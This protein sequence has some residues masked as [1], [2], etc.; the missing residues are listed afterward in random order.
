M[1]RFP[2]IAVLVAAVFLAPAA[3][4]ADSD[5]VE[6]SAYWSHRLHEENSIFASI[7]YFPYGIFRMPVGLF[8]SFRNP[9][10][11]TQAVMPPEAH[12]LDPYR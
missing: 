1:R 10:P 6:A 4:V 3:A 2:L 9:R 7:L 11:T 12:K 8:S 5:D